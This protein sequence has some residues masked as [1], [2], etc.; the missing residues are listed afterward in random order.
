MKIVKIV[1]PKETTDV[2]Y[3]IVF[4][5]TETVSEKIEPETKAEVKTEP[6]TEP[7]TEAKTEA[8][9][10]PEPKTE[11]KTE[12]KAEPKTEAKVAKKAA[13]DNG[14]TGFTF[15]N[16]K[17]MDEKLRGIMLEAINHATGK[18]FTI[19]RADAS[20]YAKIKAFLDA[21]EGQP[22]IHLEGKCLSEKCKQ[23]LTAAI[24]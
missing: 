17:H 5:G 20:L 19:W 6:K 4:E 8:K 11:A 22:C 3:R 15:E 23:E 9:A 16:Y 18:T 14:G 2:E 12:A 1:L 7:K 24:A 10:K 21:M 13:K